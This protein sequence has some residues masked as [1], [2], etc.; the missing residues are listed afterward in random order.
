MHLVLCVVTA[1]RSARACRWD[2]ASH[3]RHQADPA[4][5]P[6][7]ASTRA[8]LC[9]LAAC[10]AA[11]WSKARWCCCRVAASPL[12]GLAP[13][14]RDGN[15]A[16][17]HAGA[18]A[19]LPDLE[20]REGAGPASAAVAPVA[21]LD[22]SGPAGRVVAA[23]HDVA[24]GATAPPA[25]GDHPSAEQPPDG[26]TV[27]GIVALLQSGGL[28]APAEARAYITLWEQLDEFRQRAARYILVDAILWKHQP[29]G[30]VKHIRAVLADNS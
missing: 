11:P 18:T 8:T 29:N 21:T 17:V 9:R 27:R 23:A 24:T 1:K 6:G 30:A 25:E 4:F 10:R 20:G 2:R 3:R 19:Q 16:P 15:P 5:R 12:Y 22:V 13:S 26:E 28:V 7:C 14:G